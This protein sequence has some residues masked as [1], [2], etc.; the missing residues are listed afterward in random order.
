MKIALIGYGKMGR[1]VEMIL[2]EKGIACAGKSEDIASFDADAASF[3]LRAA[4][5]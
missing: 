3:R 1:A 2:A 5:Q 4:A